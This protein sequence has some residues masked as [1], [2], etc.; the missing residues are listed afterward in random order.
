MSERLSVDA[1]LAM[2][3]REVEALPPESHALNAD[4]LG[5][6]TA[7]PVKAVAD[8]PRFDCSA[9][10][11]YAVRAAETEAAGRPATFSLA[12]DIPAHAKADDLE[13]GQAAPIHTGSPI[14]RGADAVIAR[15]RC[16]SDGTTVEL[17]GPVDAGLNIRRRGEDMRAGSTIFAAGR[18]LSPEAI[19]ALLAAGVTTISCRRQ[20][21]AIL[22]PTG[23]ELE[24]AVRQPSSKLD[25]NGP[26]IKAACQSL[27]MDC[28]LYAP[29]VD[30]RQVVRQTLDKAIASPGADML[31]T[32]GGISGGRH[33]LVREALEELGG[34]VLFHGLAMRPGKPILFARLPDGRPLFGLPGNPV[35]ALVGFR[36]FVLAAIRRQMGLPA[37]EGFEIAPP[38]DGRDG[39]T[40]FLRGL[41]AARGANDAVPLANQRSHVMSSVLDADCWIRLDRQGDKTR[42]MIYELAAHLA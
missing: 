31:L 17:S 29:V 33:D 9:M 10:D 11:G 3:A 30:D 8:A 26:M 2:I 12:A 19:G 40:L 36:F 41:R 1:A 39:M 4:M 34:V 21:R 27:G 5:H 13:P 18:R 22:I 6:V 42:A 24:S 20:P 38:E 28:T 15:E 23:S 16:K 25:S 32:I 37:E 35:A 7:A 14:P